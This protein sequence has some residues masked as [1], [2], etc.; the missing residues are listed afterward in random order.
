MDDDLRE[1]EEHPDDKEVREE[2]RRQY[3]NEWVERYSWDYNCN[4]DR[5]SDDP[6]PDY[7]KGDDE[8][9]P[10]HDISEDD[11]KAGDEYY[12]S[13]LDY[14]DYEDEEPAVEKE[15][16]EKK[17]MSFN[18]VMQKYPGKGERK[19]G[20]YKPPPQYDLGSESGDGDP[21]FVLEG[22][23]CGVC[24]RRNIQVVYVTCGHGACVCCAKR[25]WCKGRMMR[26]RFPTWL[27]CQE[28][29]GKVNT[30]NLVN[31]E[32]VIGVRLKVLEWIVQVSER[33]QRMWKARYC[34]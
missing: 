16:V 2:E 31:G 9:K 6:E 10:E 22:N 4:Y 30:V 29:K 17:A 25:V 18:D 5:D 26:F 11:E 28:C 12:D 21:E 24:K 1:H 33:I 23:V 8:L 15:K 14:M 27:R 19:V 7:P 13:Y 34:E 20:V 32:E 3:I